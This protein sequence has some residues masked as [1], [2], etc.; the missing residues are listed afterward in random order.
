MLLK[1]RKKKYEVYSEEQREQSR[2]EWVASLSKVV[3]A[4]RIGS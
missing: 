2:V 3:R 4:V 1:N